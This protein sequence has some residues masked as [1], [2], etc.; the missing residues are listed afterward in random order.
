MPNPDDRRLRHI[1]IINGYLEITFD[2]VESA[3]YC[4]QCAAGQ[5][6]A[7]V[8]HVGERVPVCIDGH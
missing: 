4:A 1:R 2:E 3:E 7:E 6:A 8:L 5:L